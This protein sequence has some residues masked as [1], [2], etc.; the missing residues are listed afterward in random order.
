MISRKPVIS[1][2]TPMKVDFFLF[3]PPY[4]L[5]YAVYQPIIIE[6]ENLY[7]LLGIIE[8]V[9]RRNYE[10]TVWIFHSTRLNLITTAVSKFKGRMR[11]LA[12]LLIFG[13]AEEV[14]SWQQLKVRGLSQYKSELNQQLYFNA[15]NIIEHQMDF[16][17]FG[18]YKYRK[19]F[20]MD[21]TRT[22]Q[23]H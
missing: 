2:F 17:F 8:A 13:H 20:L 21:N 14:T 7:A 12:T 15:K 11:C 6:Q 3:T 22:K 10:L 1:S 18:R 9:S 16:F 5:N 4:Q 23:W 19:S